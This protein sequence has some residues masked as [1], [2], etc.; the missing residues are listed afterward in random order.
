MKPAFLRVLGGLL[1]ILRGMSAYGGTCD[2]FL[3]ELAANPNAQ[4]LN[5]YAAI[6]KLSL[7][8]IDPALFQPQTGFSIIRIAISKS[9]ASSMGGV[10]ANLP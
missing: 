4:A 2:V 7:P 5:R 1:L 3:R 9:S 10:S 6:Q 8:Q